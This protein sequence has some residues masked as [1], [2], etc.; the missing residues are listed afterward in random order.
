MAGLTTYAVHGRR[1]HK[2]KQ[3]QNTR[4]ISGGRRGGSV[5][6]GERKGSG[7]HSG[8]WRGSGVLSCARE[9]ATG[10]HSLACNW[11][12]PRQD[13]ETPKPLLS[14][15]AAAFSRPRYHARGRTPRRSREH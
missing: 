14:A 8:E 11:A 10:R 4:V 5:L 6:A 3:T 7:S 1:S 12:G 15:E 9:K 2:M 13:R